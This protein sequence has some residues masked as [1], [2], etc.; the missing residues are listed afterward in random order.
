MRTI[1][2]FLMITQCF[3]S[4]AQYRSGM[5]NSQLGRQQG[6]PTQTKI[7]SFD[8]ARAAGIIFYEAE[9]V[10]KKLKLKNSPVVPA[11]QK[12]IES[13]NK[14]MN[15][16]NLI[17]TGIFD[18]LRTVVDMKRKDA[19][20]TRDVESMRN[21]QKYVNTTLEPIRKDVKEIETLLND[22]LV[23]IISEG[24]YKKWTKYQKQQKSK[25]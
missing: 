19:M 14:K 5:R 9:H 20:A 6:T 3:Y 1:F 25:S 22:E 15:S 18:E 21:L 11:V 24:Q 10:R 7:A 23:K 13:H 2:L 4:N 17:N 16:L 8:P 12:A